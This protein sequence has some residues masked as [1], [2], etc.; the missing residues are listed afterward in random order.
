MGLLSIFPFS[1]K[2]SG[3]PFVGPFSSNKCLLEILV[4]Y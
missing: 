1:G 3:P 4:I 2:F